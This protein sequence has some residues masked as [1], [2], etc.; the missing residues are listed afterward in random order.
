VPDDTFYH[1]TAFCEFSL[2]VFAMIV[3]A[4][5]ISMPSLEIIHTST[6]SELPEA[7]LIRHEF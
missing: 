2:K 3:S 4:H 1:A 6:D 7:E 5:E